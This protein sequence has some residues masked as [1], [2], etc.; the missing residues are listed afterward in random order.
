MLMKL[1]AL[2]ADRKVLIK[3]MEAIVSKDDVTPEDDSLFAD[4][5]AE[6]ASLDSRISKLE[7]VISVASDEAEVAPEV[8]PEDEAEKAYGKKVAV[9][10]KGAPQKPGSN[11]INYMISKAHGWMTQSGLEG[12]KA[13][14]EARGLTDVR[15]ALVSNVSASGG[16]L[17]PQSFAAEFVELLNS[18]C[19]IRQGNPRIMSMPN[20]NL[21][22]PRQNIGATASYIAEATDSSV[23]FAGFDDIQMTAK[24]LTA[25][26]VMSN[27]LIRRADQGLNVQSLVQ[28]DLMD[29]L[30][31]KEDKQFMTGTGS[32]TAPNGLSNQVLAANNLGV[33]A[34][35]TSTGQAQIEAI[36]GVLESMI[37]SL[38]RNNV[39]MKSVKWVLNPAVLSYLRQLTDSNGARFFAVELAA[40]MLNNFPYLETNQLDTNLGSTTNESMIFLV[41]FDEVIIAESTDLMFDF[42]STANY[43]SGGAQVS[44]FSTDS[45][46]L[47]VIRE[48]DIALRH[49]AGMAL[50]TVTNWL[51][52][53]VTGIAGAPYA[54][55]TTVTTNSS[56]RSAVNG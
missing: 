16:S 10:I 25:M 51:P 22:I 41:A 18:E 46:V 6:L 36:L 28:A 40:G 37:L 9:H 24:K 19:V 26:T 47:R 56:A 27:D 11:A 2:K 1:K 50:A 29:Q 13:Y 12:A 39:K 14:A 23:S 20:G 38:K 32:A 35:I 52:A 48:H 43:V 33:I 34:A 4:V 8:A 49:P 17:V 7:A 5:Q 55:Q 30:S 21:T 42:S 54:T 3:K 31:L 53:N 45:T 15:K 44:A